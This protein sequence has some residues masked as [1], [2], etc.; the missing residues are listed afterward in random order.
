MLKKRDKQ[1]IGKIFTTIM[2]RLNI[3]IILN[4]HII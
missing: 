4:D 2:T 3:F 1:E